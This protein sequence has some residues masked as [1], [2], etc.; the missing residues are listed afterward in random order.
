MKSAILLIRTSLDFVSS[1]VN[2]THS[3]PGSLGNVAQDLSGLR[4]CALRYNVAVAVGQIAVG[5]TGQD[6]VHLLL[7]IVVVVVVAAS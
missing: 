3:L 1:S 5:G 2:Y 4:R 6:T 7:G